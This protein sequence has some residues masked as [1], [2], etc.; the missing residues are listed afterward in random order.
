MLK[1]PKLQSQIRVCS[2]L[3]DLIVCI[4]K[5]RYDLALLNQHCGCTVRFIA[6]K[7]PIILPSGLTSGVTGAETK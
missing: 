1:L 2:G 5:T 6:Q 3:I 7:N 4:S